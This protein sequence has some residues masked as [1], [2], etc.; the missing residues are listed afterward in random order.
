MRGGKSEKAKMRV[1]S[2]FCTRQQ[3]TAQSECMSVTALI[4]HQLQLP[5]I[6]RSASSTMSL[7]ESARK[8]VT[9]NWNASCGL[10]ST[11]I[12]RVTARNSNVFRNAKTSLGINASPVERPKQTR[13]H[14]ERS[15]T[16]F[17]NLSYQQNWKASDP[18]NNKKCALFPTKKRPRNE[19]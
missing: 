7:H 12:V 1:V 13:F 14:G 15:L 19:L 8:S 9:E 2:G 17:S 6:R 5:S 4:K 18:N 10:M 11:I 3:A 16:Y